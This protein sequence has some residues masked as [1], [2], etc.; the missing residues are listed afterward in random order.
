MA[1]CAKFASRHLPGPQ[2]ATLRFLIG[3]F[4]IGAALL[5]GRRLHVVRYPPLLLRGVFGSIAVLAYFGAIAH[6]PVGIAT[7][8]NSSS[9]LFVGFFAYLFLREPIAKKTYLAL[10]ITALGVGLVILGDQKSGTQL[11]NRS[12]LLWCLVGLGSAI[13]S[14]AAV[15]TIRAM[16]QREGAWEIFCAFCLIG[17]IVT[18]IPTLFL[19]VPLTWVDLGW[20][21]GMGV[22]AALAQVGMTHALRDVPA[23]TAVLI[24]QITPLSTLLLD[25][26]LFAQVPTSIG[27][28]GVLVTLLGITWGT[29]PT[30]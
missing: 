13:F 23:V 2:L 11:L 20:V 12:H 1:L 18:G 19:W 8:L 4:V 15:T 27:V 5:R 21:L 10:L 28:V 29:R 17:G 7:L 25:A 26:L 6:L 30:S 24:M 3:L 9:P 22:C 14:A 16:R